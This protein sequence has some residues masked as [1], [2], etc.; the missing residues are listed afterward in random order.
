MGNPLKDN[1]PIRTSDAPPDAP[2]ILPLGNAPTLFDFMPEGNTVC[3]CCGKVAS[4]VKVPECRP[5][6]SESTG[7]D[8]GHAAKPSV[9]GKPQEQPPAP[10]KN[11]KRQTSAKQKVRVSGQKGLK[12]F[13]IFTTP[14]KAENE[15]QEDRR[16]GSTEITTPGES[17]VEASLIEELRCMQIDTE[18][19]SEQKVA[20]ISLLCSNCMGN[21][22]D[23]MWKVS[24]RL[25]PF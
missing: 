6:R 18:R 11:A 14:K 21:P 3:R 23:T 8:R 20:L 4:R 25:F 1:S 15:E 9:T 13:G 10:K 22:R 24:F 5:V 19:L 17:P 7:G 12:S 16:T 2:P